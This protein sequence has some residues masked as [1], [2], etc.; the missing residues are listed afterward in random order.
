MKGSKE[1]LK[2]GIVGIGNTGNQIA[3]LGMKEL[4]I[5]VLAIN[6]SEKDL[7]TVPEGVPSILL[8]NGNAPAQG[9]GKDRSLAKKYLKNTIKEMLGSEK[10]TSFIASLDI[11]FVISST[12]GGTGSGTAPILTSVVNNMF[13]KV[14]TIL[15]GVLPVMTE[16]LSAQVNTVEYLNE[17]YS[18]LSTQTYMLYDNDKFASLPSYQIMEE[19]NKEVIKDIDVLRCKYNYTTRYDSIDEE[20]MKRLTSFQGRL[21]VSRLEDIKEKECESKSIEDMLISNIR[22]N[23]HVE[24]QR[25]RKV[26]ASGII[27]NLSETVSRDFDNHIPKVRDFVGVPIHDFN[28][29]YI[30]EERKMPNNVFLILSGLSPVN[31]KIF[32]INDRIDEIQEKQKIAE[33]E[34]AL[35][36]MDVDGLTDSVSKND[37]T[38]TKQDEIKLSDIFAQFG[39]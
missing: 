28:H 26:I 38:K 30:N 17:L 34:N 35:K 31:D 25:D 37:T 9:A 23:A 10:V 15:I 2:V 14:K 21:M 5:P 6:S 13:S 18:S 12:G 22:S 16:A 39:A 4:K 27:T 19:V 3:A 29:I 36:A 11:L 1:M 7:E 20:D 8:K 32:K 24:S 33:E